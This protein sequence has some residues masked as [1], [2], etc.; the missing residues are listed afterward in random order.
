MATPIPG[1]DLQLNQVE[2][3]IAS[4]CNRSCSFCPSGK[5]PV[6][7]QVMTPEVFDRICDE[8]ERIGFDGTV[9]LH[10]MSEPL[11]NKHLERFVATLRRRLPRTYIRIESNGDV[12]KDFERLHTLFEAGLNEVLLNCY[13][14]EEQFQA[15]N[16]ALMALE[17]RHPGTWYWN[18][19]LTNP[20]GPR[21]GW[22]MVRLRAF[23]QGDFTLRSWAGHVANNNPM[24]LDFPLKLSCRRPFERLHVNYL[25]QVLL[26]NNDWKFEVVA[27]DL[28]TQ[29][30]EEAFGSPVLQEYR[31]RLQALDR[32]MTL[33]R[34]CDSGHP[35]PNQ[36]QVP[37][38]DRLAPWRA[39]ATA[40]SRRLKALMG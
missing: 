17:A 38:A 28:T 19:W 25:G 15:R 12:L 20:S 8:M 34:N 1:T 10:L 16:A 35:L 27:G 37:P 9:G 40:I 21:H 5:F 6:P 29:S 22:R 23:Y 32:D 39:K 4:W 11:L 18:K 31:R 33:C 24:E 3:Q 7:K 2:M 13:D 30:I 36:P 14:S 26:C